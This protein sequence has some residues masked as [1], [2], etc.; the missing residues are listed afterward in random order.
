MRENDTIKDTLLLADVLINSGQYHRAIDL[1]NRNEKLR[2]GY[3]GRFLIAQCYFKCHEFVE[4]LNVLDN[5]ETNQRSGLRFSSGAFIHFPNPKGQPEATVNVMDHAYLP[6]GVDVSMLTS[7]V[8]LLRGHVHVALN[9]IALA[10]V[11]YKE[12]FRLDPFC[13]EALERLQT[14]EAVCEDDQKQILKSD[15]PGFSPAMASVIEAIYM[16]KHPE[17]FPTDIPSN[18]EPLK[19]SSEVLLNQAEFYLSL[20]HYKKVYEI[21]SRILEDDPLNPECLPV[22]ISIL[23]MLEKTNDLFAL[24]NQLVN[25][26][27]KSAI[28]WFATGT[29]CLST[30]KHDLAKR[31]LRQTILIFN[32]N[33]FLCDRV[34]GTCSNISSVNIN[35]KATQEDRRFGYAWLALG[36]AHA[37]DNEHDQAIAA[38]CTAAQVIRT[39]HIPMLYIGVEYGKSGNKKL[40]ERF[41]KHTLSLAPND[42]AV[43]HELGTLNY[44]FAN[45]DTA[46]KYL[47]AAYKSTC[48]LSGQVLAPYWE[49]LLN[50]LAFTYRQLGQLDEALEMH[51]AALKLVENSPRTLEAMA[52]VYAQQGHFGQAIRALQTA[53][54]LHASRVQATIT[55]DLLNFCH[56]MYAMQL[57]SVFLPEPPFGLTSATDFVDAAS[58]CTNK[59]DKEE[60][61]VGREITEMPPKERFQLLNPSQSAGLPHGVPSIR[62][63]LD[64]IRVPAA[65][66]QSMNQPLPRGQPNPADSVEEVSMEME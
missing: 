41:L 33:S 49:P 16:H 54:P 44:E 50:N 51:K 7:S 55:I 53:L 4:A 1:L 20:S 23:K 34:E 18:L 47:Q 2:E 60:F 42:P 56:R 61:T 31:H 48:A 27:P 37:A 63:D 3:Y 32:P 21:T 39:S 6:E 40:A 30:R 5:M 9:N 45:F 65:S 14:L 46:L 66:Y 43:L 62:E 36:H 58:R 29:Y 26:Y 52:M 57:E 8:S 19:E 15:L 38:Y 12:A 59:E 10:I 35:K 11:N 17:D 28:A 25:I 22:H 24:A 64:I 13:F